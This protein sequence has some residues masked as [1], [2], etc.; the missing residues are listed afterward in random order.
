MVTSVKWWDPLDVWRSK[1]PTVCAVFGALAPNYFSVKVGITLKLK[2]WIEIDNCY[3]TLSVLVVGIFFGLLC[4]VLRV[5]EKV[6]L[7]SGAGCKS[8]MTVWPDGDCRAL[9]WLKGQPVLSSYYFW[10]LC[11]WQHTHRCTHP[12]L[13]THKHTLCI[14]KWKWQCFPVYPVV[15][16]IQSATS[17]HWMTPNKLECCSN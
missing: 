13:R 17:Q 12:H 10:N 1:R 6:V 11:L 16:K 3:K 5:Q 15:I 8:N 7:Y 14:L 9:V 2:I 4:V